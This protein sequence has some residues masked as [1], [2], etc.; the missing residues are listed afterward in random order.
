MSI[1]MTAPVVDFK[2]RWLKMMFVLEKP[3]AVGRPDGINGRDRSGNAMTDAV[4]HVHAQLLGLF[5]CSGWQARSAGVTASAFEQNHIVP[6]FIDVAVALP[7][8]DFPETT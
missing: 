1:V 3:A 7:S 5:T 8:A 4:L 6:Y 2:I